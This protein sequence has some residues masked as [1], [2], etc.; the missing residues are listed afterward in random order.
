MSS[1]GFGR[2]PGVTLKSAISAWIATAVIAFTN[3]TLTDPVISTTIKDVNGN[4][5][6]YLPATVSAVNYFQLTNASGSTLTFKAAGSGSNLSLN[7]QTKGS[8]V[9]RLVD[10]NGNSVLVTLA[11]VASA[12]N[13]VS[14]GNAATTNAPKI[15]AAGSDTN[16]DLIVGGQG[17]GIVKDPSSNPYGVKVAVP[18]TATSTGVLGQWAADSSYIYV[19][20][21]AN[22]WRR[23]AVA[24]W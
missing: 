21:A 20:T 17:T 16:V 23:A 18:S 5:I 19:C 9:V 2:P 14:A 7:I 22:T 4:T 1:D 8:G 13:Y 6:L 11:A 15:L 24:S 12:V 3:K 10:G